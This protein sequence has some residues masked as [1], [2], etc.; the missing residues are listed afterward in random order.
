MAKSRFVDDGTGITIVKR[1]KLDEYYE[2]Q[3]RLFDLDLPPD[4]REL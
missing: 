4:D 2:D 3:P 1:S